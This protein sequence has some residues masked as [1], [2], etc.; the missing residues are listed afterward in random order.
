MADR[1]RRFPA[2]WRAD[3]IPGGYVVRDANYGTPD[4]KAW[5][6]ALMAA[7]RAGDL[8][9]ISKNYHRETVEKNDPS[10]DTL[11]SKQALIDF[12]TRHGHSPRF[13]K[14]LS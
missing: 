6:G 2:P 11:V 13:L 12:A 3:K 8:K 14:E 10:W 4:T 9:I 5:Q 7:I 1:P